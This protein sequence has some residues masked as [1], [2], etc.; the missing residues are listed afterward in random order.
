MPLEL[1]DLWQISS[2]L[3]GVFGLKNR[4]WRGKD[5]TSCGFAMILARLSLLVAFK[6]SLLSHAGPTNVLLVF[7]VLKGHLRLSSQL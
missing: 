4:G 1:R 2:E 3:V 7:E 6:R 5:G